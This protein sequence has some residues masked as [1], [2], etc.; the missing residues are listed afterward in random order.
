MFKILT[1]TA[2]LALAG[3]AGTLPYDPVY[4]PLDEGTEPVTITDVNG[5]THGFDVKPDPGDPNRCVVRRDFG[6]RSAHSLMSLATFRV[7]DEDYPYEAAAAKWL[8]T[9][10][11]DCTIAR[12]VRMD[13]IYAREFWLTCRAASG[14]SAP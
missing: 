7:I 5:S 13:R 1:I 14:A 9:H 11:R 10:G 12:S 8:G 2:A 3:C 6:G 4:A